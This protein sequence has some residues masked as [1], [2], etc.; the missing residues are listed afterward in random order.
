M[1]TSEK[2][3]LLK[4][5][6]LCWLGA[7]ALPVILHFGLSDTKFPWPLILPLLLVGPMLVSNTL[8]AKASGAA[9][10]DASQR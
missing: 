4:Q 2:S 3:S 7:L 1:T 9:M 10:D 6:T 5:N 8:L